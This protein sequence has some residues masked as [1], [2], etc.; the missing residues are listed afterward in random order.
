MVSSTRIYYLINRS[1]FISMIR[2]LRYDIN[3][4]SIHLCRENWK[5]IN[6]YWTSWHCGSSTIIKKTHKFLNLF[7]RKTNFRECFSRI[8][9]G[10]IRD[11]LNRR[12]PWIVAWVHIFNTPRLCKLKV[13]RKTYKPVALCLN[14]PWFTTVKTNHIIFIFLDSPH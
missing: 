7:L 5:R 14:V 1:L 2:F 13:R 3:T 12:L 10:S 4:C 6:I 8:G 9:R 11:L